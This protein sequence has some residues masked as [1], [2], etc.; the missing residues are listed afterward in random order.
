MI[1]RSQFLIYVII[2]TDNL[3][4]CVCVWGSVG[5]RVS[6]CVCVCVCVCVCGCVW[7]CMCVYVHLTNQLKSLIAG[8]LHI[9]Q[10]GNLTTTNA[11]K[12]RHTIHLTS[13]KSDARTGVYWT[14]QCR[15]TRLKPNSL[16]S[17]S[18]KNWRLYWRRNVQSNEDRKVEALKTVHQ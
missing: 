5:M 8:Q 11:S 12:L 14:Q 2:D 1:S 3:C 16:C 7:L 17:K 15:K 9:Y 6:G 13:S 4:A 10:D 18:V